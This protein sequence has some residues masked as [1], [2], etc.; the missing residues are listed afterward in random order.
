[1]EKLGRAGEHPEGRFFPDTY[2]F[3]AGTTDLAILKQAYNIMQKRLA[4]AWEKRDPNLSYEIPYHALIVASLIEKETAMDSERP[5][6][7][8]VILNRLQKK[9]LLKVSI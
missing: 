3:T 9:M 8:E 1:M 7:A 6:V 2:Q 4:E 5:M